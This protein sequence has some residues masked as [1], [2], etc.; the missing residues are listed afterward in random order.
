MSKYQLPDL[1]GKSSCQVGSFHALAKVARFS[2][3]QMNNA[4]RGEAE[5]QKHPPRSALELP[6]TERSLTLFAA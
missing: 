2:A 3:N 5:Q 6:A 1:A 4:I